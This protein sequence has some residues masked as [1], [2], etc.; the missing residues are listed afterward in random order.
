[1]FQLIQLELSAWPIATSIMYSL[2]YMT[3]PEQI[4]PSEPDFRNV[5]GYV[6]Y[7]VVLYDITRNPTSNPI[8]Y[9]IGEV[10]LC[11]AAVFFS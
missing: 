1:M 5:S 2:R 11:G 6:R 4:T 8:R 10:F 7:R 3:T 9:I